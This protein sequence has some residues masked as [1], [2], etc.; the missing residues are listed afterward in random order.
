MILWKVAASLVV[1]LAFAG[2]C[3]AL[4]KFLKRERGNRFVW[5]FVRCVA[6]FVLLL[7]CEY[8]L[9][10]LFPHYPELL[11][12]SAAAAV[13]GILRLADMHNSV[14]GSIIWLESTP[15]A[16]D[17]TSSCLGGV[18]FLTYIALVF[19]QPN[20][21]RNQRLAGVVGGL[22]VLLAFNTCRI[23]FTVYVEGSTGGYVHS[24]FYYVNMFVVMLVWA[25]WVSTLK[26][27]PAKVA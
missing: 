13:G 26:T 4:G 10:R 1:L 25:G 6:V 12:D 20:V 9:T 15:I 7:G 8:A 14:T 18:L 11:R 24:L 27:R 21:S 19:A 16:F 22:A 3:Y 5:F 17:I 23:A 2:S